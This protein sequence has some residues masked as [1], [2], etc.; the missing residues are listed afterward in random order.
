MRIL[1]ISFSA[2]PDGN[3]DEISKMIQESY[4]CDCTVFRF[5]EQQIHP[6]G[7]CHYECFG[8]EKP[9][10]YIGDKEY[11]LMDTVCNHDLTYFIKF[12]ITATITAPIISYLTS[13][14]NAIFSTNRNSLMYF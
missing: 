9:C 2:R 5:S 7:G 11:T 4:S 10:P 8:K 6:C 12:R 14:V 1:I 3:C 13:A